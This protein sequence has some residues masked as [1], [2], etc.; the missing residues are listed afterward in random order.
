MK[1]MHDKKVTETQKHFSKFGRR[2]KK[3]FKQD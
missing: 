3:Q 2:W 1:N